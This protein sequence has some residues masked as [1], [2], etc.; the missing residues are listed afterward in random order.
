MTERAA[1]VAAIE[2]DPDSDLP[3]LV[4]ADWLDERGD[5]RDRKRA[6]LIRVQCA[7]AHAPTDALLA[8][9]RQLLAV[10]RRVWPRELSSPWLD[11]SIE[12]ADELARPPH[13][14]RLRRAV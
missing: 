11:F 12:S 1:L 3:R 5:A 9:E 7:R 13:G 8:R 14:I 10:L 6:E 2:A 4:F